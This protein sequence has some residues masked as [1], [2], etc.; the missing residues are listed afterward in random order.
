MQ[1]AGS[2]PQ[3]LLKIT[4]SLAEASDMPVNLQLGLR[5]AAPQASTSGVSTVASCG[6]MVNVRV[7]RRHLLFQSLRNVTLAGSGKSILWYVPYM[8][9]LCSSSRIL[10]RVN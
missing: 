10:T 8:T 7:Y 5:V 9:D 3:I 4:L 6:S 1:G 2:H